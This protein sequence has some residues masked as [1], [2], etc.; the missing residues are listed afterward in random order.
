MFA[1]QPIRVDEV[2]YADRKEKG[3][4]KRKGDRVFWGSHSRYTL[5]W[6]LIMPRQKRVDEAGVIYH[7]INRGN[8]R[9][10]IFLKHEDC[11]AF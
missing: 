6:E 9:Q 7:A 5:F 11:E 4:G 8:A 3:T 2:Q 10:A 1:R